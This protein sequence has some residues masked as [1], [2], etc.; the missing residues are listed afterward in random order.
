MS[1]MIRRIATQEHYDEL[2][3][4][5]SL[6]SAILK[7]GAGTGENPF[8]KVNTL[9]TELISWLQDGA[10]SET[11]QKACFDEETSKATEKEDLEADTAKHSSIFET[12]VSRSTWTVRSQA[13]TE[14]RSTQ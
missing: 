9:I 10:S 3:Q 2:A 8:M 11:R 4:L 13:E 6:I 5:V 1:T 14:S 12:A 7:F